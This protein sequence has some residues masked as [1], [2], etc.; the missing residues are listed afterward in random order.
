MITE[1]RSTGE[2]VERFGNPLQRVVGNVW[3]QLQQ[4]RY[5]GKHTP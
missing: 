4:S 3:L 1:F 5:D 2:V